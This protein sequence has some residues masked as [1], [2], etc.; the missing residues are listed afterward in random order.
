MPLGA[1]EQEFMYSGHFCFLSIKFLLVSVT[2]FFP[3]Y[4][5]FCKNF[6]ID[7][8]HYSFVSFILYSIISPPATC[9][10]TLTVFFVVW[11]FFLTN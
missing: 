5:L 8:R 3:F 9:I 4:V 11:K 1:N 10:L 7:L 2:H 6:F